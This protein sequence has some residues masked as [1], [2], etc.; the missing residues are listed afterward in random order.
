MSFPRILSRCVV[1]LLV[2]AA[3]VL[4]QEFRGTLTGTIT[5]PSGASIPKAHVRAVNNATGQS[6]TSVTNSRGSYYIPYVLPG[7]YTVTVSANGFA[8]HVQDNVIIQANE[9]R[10]LNV[11]MQIGAAA[12]TVTVTNAPPL[13]QTEGGS[14]NT[15]LTFHELENTPLNGRQ[16]YDLIGTVPGS[17]FLQTQFGASGYSGTRGWDVS[18]NYTIGGGVQGYQQFLLDGTDITLQFH[19]SQ[20]TWIFAP[21][22]DSL[23]EMNV[24]TTTYDARFGRTGGGTVNMVT[25]E[26]TN[27]FHGEVYDYLQNGALNANNFENNLNGIPRRTFIQTSLAPP[28]AGLLSRTRSSFLALS[29]GTSRTFRLP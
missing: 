24:M 7:G 28:L 4:A 15:V 23:E 2:A 10:G 19:G 16:V 29:R 20:G 9:S 17:Q 21:N 12:Q 25:K 22:V 26:G 8:K 13:L 1:L 18:N 11:Q 3:I 14:G 27:E 5:D 6:Y